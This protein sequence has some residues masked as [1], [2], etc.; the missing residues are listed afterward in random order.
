M[1][2][3]LKAMLAAR[4]AAVQ[5]AKQAGAVQGSAE[6]KNTDLT[7]EQIQ[8]LGAGLTEQ[9]GTGAVNALETASVY[10][11][12]EKAAKDSVAVYKQL[13]LR[14]FVKG[15][16]AWV[17]PVKGY[18]YAIDDEE[19]LILGHFAAAGKVEKVEK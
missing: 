16:G 6:G 9:S 13:T 2:N 5:A 7:P 12:D 1:S 18:Y 10:E 8:A 15:S 19:A 17:V 3:D 11:L 14:K 4:S